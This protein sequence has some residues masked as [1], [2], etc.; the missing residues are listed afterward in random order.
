[1]EAFPFTKAEWSPLEDL[2]SSIL[3]AH[4]AGD[5][6]LVASIT[7]EL[8]DRLEALRTQHGDHPVLL[9]TAADYTE[10]P[11]ERAAL[12][13]RAIELAVAH[14]L[15]TLSIRVSFAPVLVELGEPAAALD[16]LQAC[17][18]E[19]AGGGAD[20]RESWVWELKQVAHEAASDAQRSALYRRAE[21]VARTYGL[22][23]LRIR[24][25]HIRFLLDIGELAAAREELHACEGEA[26]GGSE[27]DRTFWA[28]LCGEASQAEPGAAPNPAT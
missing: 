23:A 17:G 27:D 24:L 16:E 15:P 8:L 26:S 5:D 12:Y 14:G 4:S 10:A 18:R 6:V 3:N 25:L 9:E 21:E 22:P 11:A 1:M 7:L 28:Q 20:E 2:A 19:A 13:R